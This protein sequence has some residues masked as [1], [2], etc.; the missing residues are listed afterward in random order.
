MSSGFMTALRRFWWLAAIG[1]LLAAAAAVVAVY[2]VKLGVPPK[3]TARKPNTYLADAQ[4]MVDSPQVPYLRT[5]VTQKVPQPAKIVTQ[6]NGTG[7][8]GTETTKAVTP[9]PA[10]SVT[11][12]DTSVLLNAANLYPLIIQGDRVAKI[13]D[14][15]YGAVPDGKIAARASFASSTPY[16]PYRPSPI[17]VITVSGSAA[18]PQQTIDLVQHTVVAFRRWLAS[19]QK[20]SKV[21]LSQRI[22]VRELAAPTTDT[23]TTVSNA[24]YTLPLLLFLVIVALFAGLITLLDRTLRARQVR[25][26][27]A[28]ELAR[29]TGNSTA[30]GVPA[31]ARQA[32]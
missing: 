27:Y 25:Q 8:N 2:K 26:Y 10:V 3:L 30:T 17:P 16:G 20:A 4:L 23:T 32:T 12:P 9:P 11:P 21:P 29:R 13:R 6:K 14:A 31:E 22:I 7:T 18:T 28:E 19:S 15:A 5:A 24:K 1:I